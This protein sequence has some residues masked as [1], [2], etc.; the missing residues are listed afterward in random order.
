MVPIIRAIMENLVG[1]EVALTAGVLNRGD[2][3]TTAFYYILTPRVAGRLQDRYCRQRRRV[4][5]RR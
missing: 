3:L 5:A 1:V 2:E 4:Q